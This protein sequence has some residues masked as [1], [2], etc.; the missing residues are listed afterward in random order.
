M[1]FIV[2][3]SPDLASANGVGQGGGFLFQATGP[4]TLQGVET[5][6][7]PVSRAQT[8]EAI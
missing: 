6:P 1:R 7:W 3:E 5:G 8:S 2:A 4:Q